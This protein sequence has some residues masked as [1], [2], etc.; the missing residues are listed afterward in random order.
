MI[1]YTATGIPAAQTR[2]STSQFRSEYGLIQ[3]GFAS[4]NTDITALNAAKGAIAGQ[5]WT[6]AHDFSAASSFKVPT[7]VNATDAVTKS[8]ADNLVFAA[9]LPGQALGF[10]KSTGTVASF[11]ATHTGYAQN[12]VKGADIASAATINLTTATGNFVHVTGT[13]T[14][15]AITVPVGASRTVIF[16]GALMLTHGAALL[17]PGAANIM[18]AANDRMTVTGDT[19]G[20]IVTS[21]TKASGAPV[22]ALPYL[23]VREEQANGTNGGTSTSAT[24]HVRV[25]NTTVGT[26]SIPSASLASNIV[27]LPA[28]T[29]EFRAEA[30][31]PNGSAHKLS[32]YNDSDSTDILVGVSVSSASSAGVSVLA[33]CSGRFTLATAKNIKLR[34]YISTGFATNGLGLA[35]GSGSVEVYASLQIWKVA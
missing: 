17:L 3:T 32:L 24:Q 27:T 4:V 15:T 1:Y 7:P 13:T 11:G 31:C 18:T 20:A 14:V 10:L 2:S 19:A 6:G 21:Y 23:H 22:A 30:P 26:N 8:Y 5:T 16:D 34:H 25:L 28:G 29:Y 33:I 12:E 35:V 9:V